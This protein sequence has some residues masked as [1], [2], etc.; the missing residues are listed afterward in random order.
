MRMPRKISIE[1]EHQ[2][3]HR[4][5]NCGEAIFRAFRDGK[6][7]SIT[8]QAVDTSPLHLIVQVKS[9]RRV[10]RISLR[11]IDIL[12]NHNLFAKLTVLEAPP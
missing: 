7:A 11:I 8:I 6:W 9:A 1:F 5:R 10:R 2:E 3:I 4:V 12:A